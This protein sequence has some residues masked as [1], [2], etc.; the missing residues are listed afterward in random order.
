RQAGVD[1]VQLEEAVRKEARE[2]YATYETF[3]F[4]QNI[5]INP[6]EG[7]WAEFREGDHPMFRKLQQLVPNY[8]KE[9]WT[10]GLLALGIDNASLGEQLGELFFHE[11]R[12]RP[13][14]YKETFDALKLLKE[15][16]S[17]LLLTN[18]SPDLQQE[19][20]AGVPELAP[21]F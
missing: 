6:F 18:G 4:T 12:K 20:L 7:L 3:P 10:R 11:R 19:K 15:K 21:Y 5:G 14:V 16:Y 2:L 1:P 13:I 9:S 17:L 8:R